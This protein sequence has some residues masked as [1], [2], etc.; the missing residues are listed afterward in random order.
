M[1]VYAE[2]YSEGNYDEA[3]SLYSEAIEL[4]PRES[5]APFLG[6]RSAAWLMK[7]EFAKCLADCAAA[8]ELDPTFAKC[9]AR[10]AKVYM[11]TG[12]FD[13]AHAILD[14]QAAKTPTPPSPKEI[15]DCEQAQLRW[16]QLQNTLNNKSWSSAQYQVD[17]LLRETCPDS[18]TA[19]IIQV[20]CAL[21]LKQFEKAS[22]LADQCYKLD[23][24]N[25]EV[26]RVRGLS[27][28]YAGKLE[29][30]QKHFSE[31]LRFDPD[32]ARCLAL[33]KMI[34]KLES[35]KAA[36]NAFFAEGKNVEAVEKYTEALA[37]DPLN[38]EYNSVLL[39]NRSAAFVKLRNWARA[40][41]D[42]DKCLQ[43]KPNFTKAK[44]RRAQVLL[45][46]KQ[47]EESVR[48]YSALLQEDQQN[49][50]LRAGLQKAKLEL[51]KSKRKDY[52]AL[53]GVH[54]NATSTEIKKAYRKKALEW[55]SVH[56]HTG[57]TATASHRRACCE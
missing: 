54:A 5:R 22:V 3:I 1:C 13:K 19:R 8:R 44:M 35:T 48:E 52:Y 56:R 47:F 34:K 4:C 21:N 45:E 46:L 53:L 55:Q 39:S 16:K 42:V 57:C 32:N 30:A 7:K 12:E 17:L 36:G 41:E 14:E 33:F 23:A 49:A 15:K 6:N 11:Q 27:L 25:S 31:V 37:I 51:K 18:I 38:T 43:G 20:D 9:Y 50:E 28:Y 2:S 26:L 29:L 24:R 10:A 40:L